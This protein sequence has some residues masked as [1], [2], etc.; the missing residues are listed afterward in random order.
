MNSYKVIGLMSGTS[1]DGLD[2]A[3]CEFN[4]KGGQWQ[5]RIDYADTIKYTDELRSRLQAAIQLSDTRVS[6]LD[7]EY[8]KWLGNEVNKFCTTHNYNPDFIASHGHTIFHQPDRGITLQIGNGKIIHEL[9]GFPVINDFRSPDV[10]K[11][12]QGAPLVPIGDELLFGNYRYCLNL[13]GI[14]NISLNEHGNR[15]AYDICP[16]N[17]ALNHLAAKVGHPF[18]HNGGM[19]RNG[20][21]DKHLF[22]KMNQLEYYNQPFPKSL[23]LEWFVDNFLPLIDQDNPT[24]KDMLCTSAHHIAFQ[25]S[26]HLK[27]H[28]QESSSDTLLIT[29]GGAMNTFLMELIEQFTSVKIVVPNERIVNYKEALIFA[30][31][32][33]LRMRNEIN[34]LSSVTGA[35]SDSSAGT[36][37]GQIE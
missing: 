23:G 26:Q 33:V 17:M 20:Q 6:E 14:A 11:G 2:L 4:F 34:C 13:G 18:D 19:A 31:L 5:Y 12:G 37:Y 27:K 35:S 7:L 25:I 10:A 32:G 3:A 21:L 15:I 16:A 22:S 9:T 29:G 30:F 36:I 28:T 8:G 24:L 1:L